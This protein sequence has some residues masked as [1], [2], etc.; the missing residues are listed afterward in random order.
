[1]PLPR[2][3]PPPAT[4][5]FVQLGGYVSVDGLPG[6]GDLR[7][8]LANACFP[9]CDLCFLAGELLFKTPAPCA[10]RVWA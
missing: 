1:M 4:A 10:A 2:S 7:L 3:L 9:A 6:R 5:L 8:L